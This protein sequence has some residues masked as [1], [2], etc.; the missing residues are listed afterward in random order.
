MSVIVCEKKWKSLMSNSH[1]PFGKW[2][3]PDLLLR[4][5]AWSGLLVNLDSGSRQ[6]FLIKVIEYP[7]SDAYRAYMKQVSI[8]FSNPSCARWGH[9]FNG[10]KLHSRSKMS[11]KTDG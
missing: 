2:Y 7:E 3:Y 1:W 4:C 11:R 10:I 6:D 9:R 8:E 5:T